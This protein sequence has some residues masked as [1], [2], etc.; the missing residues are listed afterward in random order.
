LTERIMILK[1]VYEI[2]QEAIK[3]K[4]ELRQQW[5]SEEEI[6]VVISEALFK[7]DVILNWIPYHLMR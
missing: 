1:E 3:R 7:V 6:N 2:T 4:E 5:A